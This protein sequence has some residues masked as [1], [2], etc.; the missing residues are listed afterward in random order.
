MDYKKGLVN[1]KA[2]S[3]LNDIFVG[4]IKDIH[5]LGFNSRSNDLVKQQK[6]SLITCEQ[7]YNIIYI[8]VLEYIP[9]N[10]EQPL[11]KAIRMLPKAIKNIH[12][13]KQNN[14]IIKFQKEI[15]D[16]YFYTSGCN[17]IKKKLS[18]L[19]NEVNKLINDDDLEIL[20]DV[21]LGFDKRIHLG[22]LN[23][24]ERLSRL[25]DERR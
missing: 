22:L 6:N 3:R 9:K 16:K 18:E 15:L 10:S 24:L 13:I 14:E 20:E 2:K 21:L 12:R 1:L 8:I 7:F 25:L 5:D 4:I 11:R 23:D 17:N 19:E